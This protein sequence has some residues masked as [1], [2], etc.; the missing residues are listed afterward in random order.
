VWR[1]NWVRDTTAFD[2]CSLY[3]AAGR[4]ATFPAGI[5]P[6]FEHLIQGS[7]SGCGSAAGQVRPTPSANLLL[8]VIDSMRLGEAQGRVWATIHRGDAVHREDYVLARRRRWGVTEM[9]MWGAE[10]VSYLR[11]GSGGAVAGDAR[12]RPLRRHADCHPRRGAVGTGRAIPVTPP[13][14]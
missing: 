9:R 12:G 5:A 3:D 7:A 8:V 13:P 11:P 2:A 4:P 6:R 10:T 14:R 1:L